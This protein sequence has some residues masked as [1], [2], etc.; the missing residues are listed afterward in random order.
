MKIFLFDFVVSI[1][2]DRILIITSHY[3]LIIVI[4]IMYKF[5]CSQNLKKKEIFPS[6]GNELYNV[7]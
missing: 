3:S 5:E 1:L 6:I 2:I 4:A 7:V